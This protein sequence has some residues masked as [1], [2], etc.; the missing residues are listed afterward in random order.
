MPQRPIASRSAPQLQAKKKAQEVN[1]KITPRSDDWSA[2]YL[3]VIAESDLVD[4]APVRGCKILK[5]NGLAIWEGV[6]D[7]LDP[8]F[9][10]MGVDNA[11]FPLLI[12]LEFFS[13][14]AD[15]VAGFATECAVVTH[16]RLQRVEE[17]DEKGAVTASIQ[18]D[19]E[20]KL[21]DPYVIRPTSETI[22]WY[23][24]SKWISSYRDLPLKMNQWVNVMRW[25][26]RTKP[27]LRSAEFLWQEG[28]T[29][30]ATQEEADA[31]A[32]EVLDLYAATA[33]NHLLLPLV[34][35]RKSE[36]ERFAGAMETYT[37]E[38]LT[39]NGMALQA[40]TSHF[41]GQ[42]FAKAFDV[43]FLDEKQK[44]KHVWSTSWGVSTRLVGAVIMVHSDDDGLVMPPALAKIQVVIVPLPNKD[45]AIQEKVDA[46]VKDLKAK[47]IKAGVR[48]HVDDRPGMKPGNKYYDWER[49]GVPLRLELGARDLESGA[50]MAKMRTGGDKFPVS[51]GDSAAE[52]VTE[53]LEGVKK[54]MRS[55]ADALKEKLTF[56]IDSKEQFLE[57]M[58]QR[59][60]GFLWVPWGGDGDDEE[61]LQEE[62]GATLRCIPFEQDPVP[63]GQLCPLTGKPAREWAVFAPSY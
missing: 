36:N 32:R 45:A 48:A 55:R 59:E 47:L 22:I 8:E 53:A 37:I 39:Q 7:L 23:M 35:G 33:E 34:P 61:K 16:H 12:P 42:N 14:E 28:H 57:R 13:K 63:D 29:A 17:K 27:F 41:L 10:A 21:E 50:A 58:E 9:K 40:G 11:Y 54:V 24:Y 30:H 6:K 49:K 62:T 46:A 56:R 52:E 60:P 26:R 31:Q 51:I 20:S 15:H 2:W 4:D 44:M 25:E 18:V 1:R 5:P 3:D 43:T 38:C 19:P